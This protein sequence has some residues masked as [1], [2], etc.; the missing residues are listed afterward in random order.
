MSALLC[1]EDLPEGVQAR[2][3]AEIPYQ[4]LAVARDR[5]DCLVCKKSFK[6]HHHLIV[7]M[8]VHRGEK[9]P[10]S[11]CGKVLATRRMWMEHTKACV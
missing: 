2:E 10:C 7:H 1:G 5:K 8:G 3:F 9:F 6:T 11:K 4:I